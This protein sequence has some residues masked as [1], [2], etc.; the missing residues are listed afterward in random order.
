MDAD[1]LDLSSL[2]IRTRQAG[3]V[4]QPYGMTQTKTIKKY[5]IDRK[6]PQE[7]RDRIPL[8]FDKN[9]LILVLGHQVSEKNKISDSTKRI[10]KCELKQK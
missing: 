10:L 6:I 3:D 5:F 7:K 4:F 8:F 9:N 2:R 1:T